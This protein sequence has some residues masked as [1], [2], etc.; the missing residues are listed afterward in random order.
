MCNSDRNLGLF[1]G[2]FVNFDFNFREN[3]F[4]KINMFNSRVVV[5]FLKWLG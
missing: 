1:C 4:G 5:I 3:G 2:N